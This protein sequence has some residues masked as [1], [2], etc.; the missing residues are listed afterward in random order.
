MTHSE[1]NHAR[2]YLRFKSH[3]TGYF[4]KE[5]YDECQEGSRTAEATFARMAKK[6]ADRFLDSFLT[7]N[8]DFLD[9]P[10]EIVGELLEEV[11]RLWSDLYT[12]EIFQE[13]VQLPEGPMSICMFVVATLVCFGEVTKFLTKWQ[14]AVY[15]RSYP[16]KIYL[17]IACI[18]YS[19]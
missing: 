10:R 8:D 15:P 19:V 9:P 1:V 2:M 6:L 11:R 4:T 12:P 14:D 3:W 7:S 17:I 16:S 5:L 18:F 13:F